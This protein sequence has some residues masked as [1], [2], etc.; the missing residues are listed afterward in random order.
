MVFRGIIDE[1]LQNGITT[2]RTLIYCQTRKHC[3]LRFRLFEIHLRDKLYN[4]INRPQ[5]RIVEMYHAGTPDQVKKHVIESPSQ[6]TG[7]IRV[8]ISTI[9]FGRVN[10][11]KRVGVEAEMACHVIVSFCTMVCCQVI[12]HLK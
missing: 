9:A 1:M 12:A 7:H 10:S 2:E 8:L 6:E 5:N 11:I 4:V 3:G